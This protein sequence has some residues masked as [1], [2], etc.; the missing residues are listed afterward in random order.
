LGAEKLSVG[1]GDHEPH[2]QHA[3]NER[4]PTIF[5]TNYEDLPD[6][7]E[8]DSLKVRRIPMHSRLTEMRVPR[9]DGADRHMLNGALMIS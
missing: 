2:R 1:R 5:T 7:T 4:R 8:L 3:N 6:E 9:Y